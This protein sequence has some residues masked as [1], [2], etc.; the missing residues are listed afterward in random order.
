MQPVPPSTTDRIVVPLF[1]ARTGASAVG[2]TTMDAP[3]IVWFRR[4]L[5]LCDHAALVSAARQ[6][7]RAL[8]VFVYDDRLL[9]PA[10]A[11][12]RA[13]LAGCLRDLDR[14]LDSK[15]LVCHGDPAEVL[16][17]IAQLVGACSVHVSTETNPYG[18]HR[19]ERVRRAGRHRCAVDGVRITVCRDTGP[20]HE[21][22]RPTVPGVHTLPARLERARLAQPGSNRTEHGGL[23]GPLR[24]RRSRHSRPE[25][26]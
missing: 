3:A 5:R 24:P 7:T 19:G 23:D 22:R 21:V 1:S 26:R 2:L 6:S 18:R 11:P 12:R 25:R 4:D 9:A 17:G 13:F 8:A 20:H 14:Q 15:L 16:P 10:G